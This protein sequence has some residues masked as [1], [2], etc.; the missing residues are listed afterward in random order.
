MIRLKSNVGT[1]DKGLRI[2]GAMFFAGAY[3]NKEITGI[4]AVVLLIIAGIFI[5]TSFIS[6]CP[7]YSIFKISTHK[8]MD[9]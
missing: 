6:F 2:L 3:Y 7:L 4:T 1:I 8:K 5:V 9:G